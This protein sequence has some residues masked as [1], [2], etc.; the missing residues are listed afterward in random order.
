MTVNGGETWSSWYNQ[1]TA[2]M[3]HV[4]TDNAFP[5]RVCSGQ[6]ESGS[7]CVESRGNDGE[8]TFR[9]WHPVGVEEYGYAVPDPLNPDLVFGGKL[10]RYDRRT[11]Q[12]AERRSQAHPHGRFPHACAP[13]PWSSRRPIRTCSSSRPT[14]F[15]KRATAARAGR[16][17]SPDLTRKTWE[18]PASIGKYSGEESAKPAQRGVIYTV[19]P[20]PLDINRIWAGTD[21]G[22]IQTTADGG[23]HWK[24]VTP[25]R[26]RA[27][28]EGLDHGRR[29]F[30]R[31]HRLCRRQHPAPRRSAPAHFPHPRRRQD[32]DGDREGSAGGR[33]GG[34]GP[35]GSQKEG[36]AVRRHRARRLRL[37]RRRRRT[38]SRCVSTCRPVPSATSS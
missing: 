17:I 23:L 18:Q 24:N 37:L 34:R 3:Y 1:P 8:I 38:G 30:R 5:Y 32:L 27:L 35:R 12:V 4:N 19:A 33:S 13:R 20:S 2:Q 22:L 26:D 29:P 15:G 25:P 16:K 11:G 10:T 9:E 36:A 7:A 31:A 14:R 6:Q 21:D 28:D